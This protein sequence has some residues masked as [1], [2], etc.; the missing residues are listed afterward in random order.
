MVLSTKEGRYIIVLGI[1]ISIHPI[2][3]KENGSQSILL[4]YLTQNA[5][6]SLYMQGGN[7]S[8]PRL[9][10]MVCQKSL[11]LHWRSSPQWASDRIVY[12]FPKDGSK[13]I[14]HGEQQPGHLLITILTELQTIDAPLMLIFKMGQYP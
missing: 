13:Y 5:A 1:V 10:K 12:S 6:N 9:H 7:Q 14:G 2:S 11:T 8:P 3:S 4:I